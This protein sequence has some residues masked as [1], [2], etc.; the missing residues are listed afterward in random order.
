M[1][2][3][4]TT[5]VAAAMAGLG[6]L[7]VVATAGR[8]FVARHRPD[9]DFVEL[10]RRVQ[11]WWWM[12]G[13]LLAFLVW[14]ITPTVAFLGFI[15]F[16]ALKEMLSI[17]PTRLADRR[18]IFWAYGAI[19]VQ[20]VLIHRGSAFGLAVFVPVV[21]FLFLPIRA[22]LIGE[23]TGFVR[24]VTLVQWATLLTVF[25][26]GHLAAL[27]TMPPAVGDAGPIGLLLFV[28]FMTQANDVFQFLWG[29]SVGGPKIVPRISPGKTWSGFVGGAATTAVVAA[30]VGPWLTPMT[31]SASFGVGALIAV[32][33]FFGDCVMSAIKRD[34][35]IKDSGQLIPGHG[36]ILDRLDSVM[37]TAP[38][39][40]YASVWM[41]R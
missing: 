32:V 28:L 1:G 39:F 21:L 8:L 23:T 14:G 31:A 41:A 6:G 34:L 10:R 33:G 13:V 18:M 3:D 5:P 24:S 19:P 35:G 40:Y 16:L 38:A 9:R 7:L 37:Y 30:A 36:G 17:V 26:L 12:V 2:D 25:C 11:S 22:V 4:L 29:K 27:L 15:S 20:Y